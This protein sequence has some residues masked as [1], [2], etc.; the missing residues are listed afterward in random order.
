MISEKNG[1]KKNLRVHFCKLLDKLL[2]RILSIYRS[3]I[4]S[5]YVRSKYSL[6]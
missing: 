6:F 5:V 1:K 4:N 3:C 2:N